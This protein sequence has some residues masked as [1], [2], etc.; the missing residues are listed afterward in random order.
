MQEFIGLNT[1][2]GIEL[3]GAGFARDCHGEANHAK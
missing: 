2:S 3:F 1:H